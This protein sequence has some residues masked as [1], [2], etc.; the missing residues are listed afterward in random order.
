MHVC[1]IARESYLLSSLF[2]LV[3]SS[4]MHDTHRFLTIDLSVL[5][6]DYRD[7]RISCNVKEELAGVQTAFSVHTGI[8]A[9]SVL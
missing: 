6:I 2:Y 3:L 5:N 9:D 1:S 4:L 8:G 7:E